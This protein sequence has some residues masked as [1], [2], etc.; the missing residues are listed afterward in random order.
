[1][2][3]AC[4]VA[5]WRP[6]KSKGHWP[7]RVQELVR[8]LPSPWSCLSQAT[9]SNVASKSLQV[10]SQLSLAGRKDLLV[11]RIAVGVHRDDR[12]EICDLEFPNRFR[13]AEFFH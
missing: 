4:T 12:R 3:S 10:L 8:A 6:R 2:A 9:L 5:S 1:M 7:S 13:G 11:Q